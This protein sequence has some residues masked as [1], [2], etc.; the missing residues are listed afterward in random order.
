MLYNLKNG[1][2]ISIS[3]DK[4]LDMSDEELDRLELYHR[5]AEINDPFY[6]SVL[7][8]EGEEDMEEEPVGIDIEKQDE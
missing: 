5:G 6:A 7:E 4:Y 3:L 8:D 1:T 2:T